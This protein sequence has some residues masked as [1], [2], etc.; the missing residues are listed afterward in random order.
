MLASAQLG[1]LL[2][3][4][5]VVGPV[6]G[7]FLVLGLLNSRRTPQMLPGGLDL[8]ILLTALSPVLVI[9]AMQWTGEPLAVLIAAA[10]VIGGIAAWPGR[11]P[12]WVIYNLS[13]RQARQAVADGLADLG[14]P[15]EATATGFDL[16]ARRARVAVSTFPLLRNATVRLDARHGEFACRLA[17][18]IQDRLDRH[19]VTPS[20]MAVSLL[21]VATGMLVAP[22]AMLAPQAD[23][24]VR[25]LTNLLP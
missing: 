18:C 14:E 19:E 24:I 15:A 22:L 9:P 1:T 20:P 11:A 2:Q 8:A 25:L 17:G 16:P 4:A 13:A 10:G 3:V 21:L 6:A 12:C 5:L 7:Y 23:E